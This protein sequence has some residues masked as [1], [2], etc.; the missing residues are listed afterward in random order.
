MYN[1]DS[2]SD[3]DP[4]I[5]QYLHALSNNDGY[6]TITLTLKSYTYIMACRG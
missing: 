4:T 2:D 1:L 6:R 3:S 5:D